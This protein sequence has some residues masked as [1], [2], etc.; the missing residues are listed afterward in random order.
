LEWCFSNHVRVKVADLESE[1]RGRYSVDDDSII[2]NIGIDREEVAK[3]LTRQM[4][5]TVEPAEVFVA[6]LY[7]EIAHFN[8]RARLRQIED[9]EEGQTLNE[10]LEA[11]KKIRQFRSEAELSAVN[12]SIRE[13]W[14]WRSD[15]SAQMDFRQW[16]ARKKGK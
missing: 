13:F 7:H 14:N 9:I 10:N 5:I 2:L 3:L 6:V 8:Q 15:S 11:L 12:F 16:V 4:G 1:D